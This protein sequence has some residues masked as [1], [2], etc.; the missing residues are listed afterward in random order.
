MTKTIGVHR[1]PFFCAL[2]R[3]SLTALDAGTSLAQKA[4]R[5]VVKDDAEDI[6]VKRAPGTVQD[7]LRA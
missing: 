4:F 2:S 7:W 5:A 6:R 1:P 3:R